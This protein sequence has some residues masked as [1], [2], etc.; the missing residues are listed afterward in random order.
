MSP[1]LFVSIVLAAAY[2]LHWDLAA[3]GQTWTQIAQGSS[4]PLTEE[5][6]ACG[7]FPQMTDYGFRNLNDTA[8]KTAEVILWKRER[9]AWSRCFGEFKRR[10]RQQRPQPQQ[11][12]TSDYILPCK[13]YIIVG[14]KKQCI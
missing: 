4:R 6:N 13:N 2:C 10:E 3:A 11:Q 9:D 14:S 7:L 1:K 12:K 5:E 8:G